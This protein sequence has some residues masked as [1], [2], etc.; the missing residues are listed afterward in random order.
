MQTRKGNEEGIS[1]GVIIRGVPSGMILL[2]FCLAAYVH[3]S[4]K[5]MERV[6]LQLGKIR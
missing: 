6:G 1:S 5:G 4:G 2:Q 3:A